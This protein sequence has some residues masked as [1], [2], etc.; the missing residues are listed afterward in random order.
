MER[1]IVRYELE[2]GQR[3]FFER[4]EDRAEEGA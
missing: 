2:R 4:G 3:R 1:G